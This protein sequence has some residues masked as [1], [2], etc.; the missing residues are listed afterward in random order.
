MKFNTASPS[1]A[2]LDTASLSPSPSAPPAH[3][4]SF[5]TQARQC[6]Q[7]FNNLSTLLSKSPYQKGY[8]RFSEEGGWK[9][10]AN[11][12]LRDKLH[13][14]DAGFSKAAINPAEMKLVKPGEKIGLS[15]LRDRLE[16]QMIF[17]SKLLN[18]LEPA[19]TTLPVDRSRKSAPPTNVQESAI[20]P[21]KVL[22]GAVKLY[23]PIPTSH[24]DLRKL[25]DVTEVAEQRLSSAS[26]EPGTLSVKSRVQAWE[27]LTSTRL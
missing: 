2:V 4:T 27:N 15:T 19:A 9:F 6:S 20:P 3:E 26:D 14:R 16:K 21:R 1:F 23:P 24:A 8:L 17:A 25:R 11:M 22:P 12:S 18:T 5:T 7:S 13:L 10:S